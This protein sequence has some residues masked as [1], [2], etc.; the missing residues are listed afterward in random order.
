MRAQISHQRA[1]LINCVI[2]ATLLHEACCQTDAVAKDALVLGFMGGGTLTVAIFGILGVALCFFRDAWYYPTLCVLCGFLLPAAAL[3]AIVLW[4]K[5][6]LQD[7][8]TAAM[9]P[10]DGFLIKQ[11]L[12]VV[13]VSIV[14]CCALCALAEQKFVQNGVRRID[15]EVGEDKELAGAE[16]TGYTQRQ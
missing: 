4:P 7:R 5:K 15:S 16:R 8:T 12:F 13:F 1:I 6:E 2:A 11:T 3:L 10:T 14:L 9:P